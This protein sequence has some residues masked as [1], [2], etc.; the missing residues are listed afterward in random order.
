MGSAE[1]E[2]NDD[3]DDDDDHNYDND[4]NVDDDENNTN[5]H[6]SANI[7]ARSSRFCMVIHVDSTYRL[8]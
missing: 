7:Q 8:M 4:D 6:N 1:D 5:W 3:I 2:V